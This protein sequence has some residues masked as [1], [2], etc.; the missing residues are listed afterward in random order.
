MQR[1]R[2]HA[3]IASN[4]VSHA[5]LPKLTI[6]DRVKYRYSSTDMFKSC[7]D[8]GRGLATSPSTADDSAGPREDGGVERP[9]EPREAPFRRP[10]ID[11]RPVL[12]SSYRA[13]VANL[14][15]FGQGAIDVHPHHAH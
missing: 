15:Q 14:F 7:I 4:E 12:I 10:P 5:M 8:G 11:D 6:A 3:Q 1:N 9:H 2:F 13:F